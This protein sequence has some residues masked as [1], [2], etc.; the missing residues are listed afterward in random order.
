MAVITKFPVIARLRA[1]ASHHVI[2]YRNGEVRQSGRGIVFW[3]RPDVTSI[4]EIP[5]DDR[6]MT[7]FVKG[8]SA[9]FQDVNVQ[10]ALGWRVAGPE[11]LAE[12]I[13]FTIDLLNGQHVRQPIERIE[14]RLTGLVNQ[15]ALD[16][17]AGATVRELLDAG[18]EPL[19]QRLEQIL[20]S[21]PVLNELGL[22][23]VS[24]RLNNLAPSSEL[25][26][27]LQT[28]TFEALQQ[29][30]DEA[31]FERRAL[32]VDKERAIAENEL[33]NKVELARREK[34]LI[35]EEADNAR[36]RAT[37]I[38]EAAKV[39]AE[40]EANRIRTVESAKAEAEQAHIAV[41]RDL[42]A[43]VLMGLAA[44]ELAGK[45]D[46]IEHLNVTP[47]VLAAVMREFAMKPATAIEAR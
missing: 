1:D 43:S 21:E 10:G 36:N 37:G 42:P 17:L 33:A 28:P 15:A 20:A 14:A 6:E 12:R 2:R 29:K 41:Y 26:R 32:A 35:A 46:T 27:A 34:Q 16:Y 9:D 40:A 4:V 38:A 22:A 45:L 47:D 25:E 8:R 39:E 3:F 44:R 18:I 7:L 24:V 11:K 31:M 5:M 19:R 23:I 30:A 13:D